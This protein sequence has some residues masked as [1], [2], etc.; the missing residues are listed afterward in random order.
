MQNMLKEHNKKKKDTEVAASSF[1]SD[2]PFPHLDEDSRPAQTVGE[3][4]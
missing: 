3:E 4:W 1:N 2:F